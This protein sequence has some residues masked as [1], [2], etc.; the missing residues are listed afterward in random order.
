MF[1][2][3]IVLW[4]IGGCDFVLDAMFFK[5]LLDMVGH[6]FTSSVR[7]EGFNLLACFQF[8][9]SDKHLEQFSNFRL[10]LQG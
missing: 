5:V 3:A 6:I 1:C 8:C 2:H 9:P 7:A 4:C 10:L